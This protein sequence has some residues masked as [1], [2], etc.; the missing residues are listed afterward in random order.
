MHVKLNC[1]E[2]KLAAYTTRATNSSSKFEE[3]IP[4][5]LL[6]DHIILRRPRLAPCAGLAPRVTSCDA[7]PLLAKAAWSSASVLPV[8]PQ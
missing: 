1:I 6:V 3:L 8:T 5:S 7:H 2:N 4:G